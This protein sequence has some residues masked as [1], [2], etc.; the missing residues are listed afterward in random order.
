M[1]TVQKTDVGVL[2]SFFPEG[3]NLLC[4]PP[5]FLLG[6]FAAV[7]EDRTAGTFH[8]DEILFDTVL[9]FGNERIGRREDLRGGT[10]I[11]HHQDGLHIRELLVKVQKIAYIG[12]T[13]DLVCRDRPPRKDSYDSR[14]ALP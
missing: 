4:D 2:D 7:A 8:G 5:G 13:R 14:R 1:G 6:I 3:G 10:V 11:F 12:P 9:V